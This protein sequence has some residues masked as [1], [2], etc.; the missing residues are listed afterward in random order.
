MILV[1]METILL[2]NYEF[3]NYQNVC[4][5]KLG[6]RSIN[7]RARVL[8]CISLERAGHQHSRK[9]CGM[10][11]AAIL[12]KMWTSDNIH[13]QFHMFTHSSTPRLVIQ[14]PH[15][16]SECWCLAVVVYG[17]LWASLTFDLWYVICTVQI[18]SAQLSQCFSDGVSSRLTSRQSTTWSSLCTHCWLND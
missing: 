9:V 3:L 14:I 12:I 17:W 7:T 18:T 15:T 1:A 4:I 5:Y 10:C 8:N 6:W 13:I 11:I 16:V 2:G